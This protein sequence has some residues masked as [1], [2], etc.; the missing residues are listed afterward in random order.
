M[1]RAPPDAALVSVLGGVVLTA[2]LNICMVS[3]SIASSEGISSGV[4]VGWT[5]TLG[6][7]LKV[8]M[9]VFVFGMDPWE[10]EWFVGGRGA[11]TANE[12]ESKMGGLL[13]GVDFAMAGAE[14]EQV[15]VALGLEPNTAP[16]DVGVE[17]ASVGSVA[18]VEGVAALDGGTE[19]GSTAVTGLGATSGDVTIPSDS[20]SVACLGLT[21]A[22][23]TIG[24]AVV[25][26]STG[27]LSSPWPSLSA[28]VSSTSTIV[29]SNRF[30]SSTTFCGLRLFVGVIIFPFNT[31][32]LS[33][34]ESAFCTFRGSV[35]SSSFPEPL[36]LLTA[37]AKA[38][39]KTTSSRRS[40]CSSETSPSAPLA[41]GMP[42]TDALR[43]CSS[44]PLE[45]STKSVAPEVASS[46]LVFLLSSSSPS[47]GSAMGSF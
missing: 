16:L 12:S 17:F 42:S 36:L 7:R 18:T 31:V 23:S 33:K 22:S 24:A 2:A 45:A 25:A 40:G 10:P 27:V 11:G 38:S 46:I 13:V 4:D 37:E 3:M 32:I 35:A 41:R 9:P 39:S 1:D 30:S 21:S 8:L 47:V 34:R 14:G 44:A 29:D 43:L 19:G 15:D 26:F 20:R 6:F 28:I 5:A